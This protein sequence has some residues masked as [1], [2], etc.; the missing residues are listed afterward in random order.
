MPVIRLQLAYD[1][2]DF[3]GYQIQRNARTV[4]GKLESALERLHAHPV[5]T[6]CAGRTDAGVHAAAQYVSF[7]SDHPGIPPEQFGAAINSLLPGDVSVLCS[8]Q[9][10]DDFHAQYQARLRH[11]RYYLFVG[12]VI[13]PHRRRY[14]WRLPEMPRIDR[15]NRDTAALVGR[16]D[17]S[18][19]SMIGDPEKS[20]VRDVMYADF[21]RR[22]N[23]LEFGIGATGFLRRMVRSIVGT[24][25]ERERRRLRGQ[26]P[27]STMKAILE[28]CDRRQA[29]TT[30]PAWG[31]FLHDV[32]YDV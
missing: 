31:L 5:R 16:H 13:P 26:E 22:G 15:L 1:G 24:V 20:T 30:A 29:G 9:V 4:Q 8:E 14:A 7:R 17:F 23:T 6:V 18:T 11:Y 10:P 21:R 32:D 27:D 28:R 19:F 2:T 3:A 25:I 12:S